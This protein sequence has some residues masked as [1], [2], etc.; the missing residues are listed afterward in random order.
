MVTTTQASGKIN[1]AEQKFITD[2]GRLYDA[3]CCFVE[4]T[5]QA[6]QQIS[7]PQL[8]S[9][10]HMDVGQNEQQIKN[11]EQIFQMMG[12]RP[13][14]IKS[15]AA[16]ALVNEG[17]KMVQEI[18]GNSILRDATIAAGQSA[19]KSAESSNYIAMITAAGQKGKPEVVAL[20]QQNLL[21]NQEAIP[22]Y[23]LCHLNLMKQ[24]ASSK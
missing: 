14:R 22:S 15:E 2:L 13:Q 10:M 5:Q 23:G 20:L 4:A 17:K 3:K 9:V 1:S 7:N 12:G 11:L 21:Q 8:K 24:L 6:Q 16:E 19:V 18:S